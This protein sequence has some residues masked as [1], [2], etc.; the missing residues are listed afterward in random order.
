MKIKKK[1]KELGVG[2]VKK[3]PLD[4]SKLISTR[5]IS[6]IFFFFFSFKTRKYAKL[7]SFFFFFFRP[8]FREELY[9]TFLNAI[10]YIYIFYHTFMDMEDIVGKG[11]EFYVHVMNNS[12]RSRNVIF[13][14]FF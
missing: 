10:N 11:N 9:F 7:F 14:F 12:F 1:K 3:R 6:P 13:F 5:Y 4:I 8:A 2:N